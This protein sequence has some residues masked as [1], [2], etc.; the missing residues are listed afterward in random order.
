ML[1][2]THRWK[3]AKKPGLASLQT[4][5][6][7]VIAGNTLMAATPPRPGQNP[8]CRRRRGPDEPGKQMTHLRNGQGKHSR[9]SEKLRGSRGRG[10]ETL[11]GTNPGQEGK[12]HQHQRDVS[13][14]ASEAAV[15]QQEDV[16]IIP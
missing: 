1:G 5:F 12:S 13:V 4:T 16:T 11:C 2:S 9:S 8:V 15:G 14:P 10:G 7:V 6:G 3:M